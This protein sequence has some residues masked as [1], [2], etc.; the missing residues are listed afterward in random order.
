MTAATAAQAAEA[1]H[2]RTAQ[3]ATD[4]HLTH[5]GFADII[6]DLEARYVDGDPS[7]TITSIEKAKRDAERA[8][9]ESARAAAENDKAAQRAAEAHTALAEEQ[10]A[11]LEARITDPDD[12]LN[13]L[14]A[15]L[16]ALVARARD[17]IDERHAACVAL[18]AA[19]APVGPSEVFAWAQT[20]GHSPAEISI[21][22]VG[23]EWPSRRLAAAIM[24]GLK[25]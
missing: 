3:A 13:R 14:L 21:P 16:P 4:A 6:A 9:L 7:V 25:A 10:R 17:L 22:G 19:P 12:E 11:A 23:A 24:A 18:R 20:A 8:R 15:E 1:E 5:V 2:N